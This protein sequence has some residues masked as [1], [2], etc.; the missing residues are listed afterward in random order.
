MRACCR[1]RDGPCGTGFRGARRQARAAPTAREAS[2][3]A[4]PG[5]PVTEERCRWPSIRAQINRP[6]TPVRGDW[7]GRVLSGP[8]VVRVYEEYM[9]GASEVYG[10]R[11]GLA[12]P[13]VCLSVRGA[14]GSGWVVRVQ[15]FPVEGSWRARVLLPAGLAALWPLYMPVR[16]CPQDRRRGWPGARTYSGQRARCNCQ[17]M[18][19][20]QVTGHIE[21]RQERSVKPSA[22]PTL[23]RTQHLPH[24][25]KTAR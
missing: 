11:M 8:L 9:E 13:V 3:A 19:F 23:V 4:G 24:P 16:G 10:R 25:A 21:C 1:C 2:R 17:E 15:S 20:S 22:Q 14:L 18:S 5:S 7:L 12:I 6:L